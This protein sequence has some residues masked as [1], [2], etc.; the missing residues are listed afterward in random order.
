MIGASSSPSYPSIR[1]IGIRF[2]RI[3]T[4]LLG[5]LT[6]FVLAEA[7]L[8]ELLIE[9]LRGDLSHAKL[10]G[11][12]LLE[13][14]VVPLVLG[15]LALGLALVGTRAGLLVVEFLLQLGLFLGLRCLLLGLLLPFSKRAFSRLASLNATSNGLTWLALKFAILRPRISFILG[16]RNS[17]YDIAT[18]PSSSCF[19][20]K[21]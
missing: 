7:A 4:I 15:R 1:I 5:V 14:E 16:T 12:A 11:Q 3:G 9:L 10:L 21:M 13:R 19:T 6:V 17:P 18:V 2:V 20:T 8:P